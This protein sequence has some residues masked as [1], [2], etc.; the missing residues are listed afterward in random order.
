[1]DVPRLCKHQGDSRSSR[2]VDDLA[3]RVTKADKTGVLA[4]L[5][6]FVAADLGRVQ[7]NKSIAKLVETNFGQSSR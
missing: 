1:L 6:T 2:G 5:P 3:A 4:S 7:K